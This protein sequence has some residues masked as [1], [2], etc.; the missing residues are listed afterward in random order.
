MIHRPTAA[1]GGGGRRQGGGLL[2]MQNLRPH[3]RLN[4]NL[5]LNK[6]AMWFTHTS[7][8]EK[9][10]FLWVTVKYMKHL[11][12]SDWTRDIH[13]IQVIYSLCVNDPQ[14]FWTNELKHCS[15]S[16]KYT[17]LLVAQNPILNWENL[18]DGHLSWPVFFTL[19]TTSPF[20]SS[21]PTSTYSLLLFLALPGLRVNK[22]VSVPTMAQWELSLSG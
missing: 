6:M 1:V 7:K 21:F 3:P 13:W 4:Q 5:H 16:F 17:F 11:V 18:G 14:I 19:L 8:F 20:L 9:A 22:L 12:A 10:G 2:Q 15:W